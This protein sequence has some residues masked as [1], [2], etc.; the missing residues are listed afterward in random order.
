M[1]S[2]KLLLV[3]VCR[4]KS[5]EDKWIISSF[6]FNSFVLDLLP[7]DLE[8]IN[9][10]LL[11]HM[12]LY[13]RFDVFHIQSSYNIKWTI[14]HQM[15]YEHYNQPTDMWKAS[16]ILCS[17]GVNRKILVKTQRNLHNWNR[18]NIY[19]LPNCKWLHVYTYWRNWEKG[20]IWIKS[21]TCINK[22]TF[23]SFSTGKG[24]LVQNCW[25]LSPT[26]NVSLITPWCFAD[27][28]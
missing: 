4:A 25:I 15:T 18:I 10:N 7:C 26:V 24:I 20:L 12:Y 22:P 16:C 5:S 21:L 8:K 11:L 2:G 1:G 6:V 3:D 17:K 9:K 19:K 28:K 13:T 14:L 27:T 23:S